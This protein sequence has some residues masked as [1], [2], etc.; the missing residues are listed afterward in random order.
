MKNHLAACGAIHP[1]IIGIFTLAVKD[2]RNTRAYEIFNPI[3]TRIFT[4]YGWLWQAAL[5]VPKLAQGEHL[6]FVQ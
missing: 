1:Q 6:D 3:H 2:T 5:S 4:L